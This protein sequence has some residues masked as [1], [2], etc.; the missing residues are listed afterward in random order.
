MQTCKTIGELGKKKTNRLMRAQ[1]LMTWKRLDN[2][3]Q[4][5]E[6]FCEVVLVINITLHYLI[7]HLLF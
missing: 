5:I 1:R 4:G 7:V 3:L 2:F 6:W